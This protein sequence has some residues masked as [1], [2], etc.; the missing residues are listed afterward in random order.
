MAPQSPS[1][2]SPRR[3]PNQKLF[4]THPATML[5][6]LMKVL[7]QVQVLD[8]MDTH[9]LI[10]LIPHVFRKRAC[11]HEVSQCFFLPMA[12]PIW[13]INT[14]PFYSSYYPFNHC[15]PHEKFICIL[16]IL[17]LLLILFP[18][19]WWLIQRAGAPTIPTPA[20]T[21]APFYLEDH[22]VPSNSL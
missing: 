15:A 9:P 19:L 10:A 18:I 17:L 11:E 12:E 8:H 13:S 14:I 21:L 6:K 16:L 3:L 1:H 22:Q 20:S 2:C 4:R 5:M 7:L